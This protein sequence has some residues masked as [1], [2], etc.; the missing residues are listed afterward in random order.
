MAA[1]GAEDGACLRARFVFPMIENPRTFFRECRWI[2]RRNNSRAM[3]LFARVAMVM[4]LIHKFVFA[5]EA[6]KGNI[7]L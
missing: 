4:I 3:C 7:V 6:S 2:D 5:L 1:D